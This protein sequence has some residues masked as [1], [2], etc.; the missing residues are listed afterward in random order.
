MYL[1]LALVVVVVVVV[2]VIISLIINSMTKEHNGLQ[3]F[4]IGNNVYRAMEVKEACNKLGARVATVEEMQKAAK[5]GASWN[6]LGW[7]G[8]AGDSFACYPK[9]GQLV[10]SKMPPQIKL[11]ANCYGL[12]MPKNTYEHILPWNS[13]KWAY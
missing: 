13:W 8:N 6:N 4:Q 11:G 3:V 12:K 2:I 5:L 9:N 1:L 7:S 10:G